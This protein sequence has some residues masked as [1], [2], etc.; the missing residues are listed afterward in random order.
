MKKTL[1]IA[2][3]MALALMMLITPSLA[4][5]IPDDTIENDSNVQLIS[6]EE[7]NS[8]TTIITQIRMKKW[9]DENITDNELERLTAIEENSIAALIQ[10]G[11]KKESLENI[12]KL[13]NMSNSQ[14]QS[15]PFSDLI[16]EYEE[17]YFG[18][19]YSTTYQGDSMYYLNI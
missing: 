10:G 11:Y 8:L 16:A 1:K 13:I 6:M 9:S 17:F 12:C 18:G 7:A 5:T 3:S 19:P 15:Y 14:I 4:I 2:V